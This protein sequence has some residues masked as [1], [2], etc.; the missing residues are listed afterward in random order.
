LEGNIPPFS[1]NLTT[2]PICTTDLSSFLRLSAVT[3]QLLLFLIWIFHPITSNPQVLLATTD[4]IATISIDPIRGQQSVNMA[5]TMLNTPMNSM[6][7]RAMAMKYW[8][9]LAIQLGHW[10]KLK[11]IIMDNV[12]YDLMPI[13]AKV[14]LAREMG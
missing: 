4:F 12:M 1:P 8:N 14:E 10:N 7:A 11:V 2:R 9:H 5:A 3:A 6:M 13:Q